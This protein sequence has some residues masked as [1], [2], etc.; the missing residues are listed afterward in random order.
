[1]PSIIGKLR[2]TLAEQNK[3]A[4]EVETQFVKAT[5][6][7]KIYVKK[8]ID[9]ISDQFA[10]EMTE[11][12]VS[13]LKEK[14]S[15]YVE[16]ICKDLD[17]KREEQL[18]IKRLVM[19]TVTGYGPID[20]LM[21]DP[22]VTEIV[23]QSWDNIV[24]E[25]NGTIHKTDAVF[26]D[27]EHLLKVIE[28]IVQRSDKQINITNPIV[29][30]RLED[31]SRVN[32]TIPPVSPY[33]ATLTIRKFNQAVYSGEDYINIGTL[34]KE[35]LYFL[36][37]C[38]Q[39]KIT[40]FV[41]GGTGTGKTTM[42]NML[43]SYIPENELIITIEDTLELKLHQ[44]NIRRMEVRYASNEGMMNV[45]Q[46]ILVKAALRQRPDRIILGETRDGSVV[47]LIS[48]MST[49]HE[50]SMSTIHANSPENMVNVR[51]PILYS[52][53]DEASFSERSISLQI[54]EAIQVIVQLSRMPDG[55]RKVTSIGYIDRIDK[56][57][58]VIVKELFRYNQKY[59]DF[60]ATGEYPEEII[61]KIRMKG[62]DF[63]EKCFETKSYPD[64]DKED[65]E[66]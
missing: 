61:R 24:Y 35:M 12:S 33:G 9:M 49:G 1:M 27:E 40:L 63:D 21:T 53:N 11:K 39:G 28:R 4:A 51:I 47:D 5:E 44:K 20:S 30:T 22:E 17:L 66:G 23:V 37:K 19:L 7:E 32:A 41:S 56:N 38:V 65:T 50:G 36:Q 58:K 15:I 3:M 59:K 57:D 54:A 55:S 60:E 6:E 64:T 42:L 46:K 13:E 52:M 18:R 8:I 34:N 25:K 45:D 2:E 14:I 29:D 48:A 31:G 10:E 16:N 43:S 62:Y 26:N